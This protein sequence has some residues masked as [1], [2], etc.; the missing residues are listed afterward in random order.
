M[1]RPAVLV[2]NQDGWCLLDEI[3]GESLRHQTELEANL[4]R[5]VFDVLEY[6]ANS[7][8]DYKPNG[9]KEEDW[10]RLYDTCL[11]FLYRLLFILYAESRYL[12]P[13]RSH[14]VRSNRTYL[15]RFALATKLD[16]LRETEDYYT[17]DNLT[18]LY[19][20]LAKLF[21]LI[22]GNNPDIN[23][24]CGVTRYNG[25]LF[26]PALHPEIE[27]LRVPDKP[28]ADVLR[29]LMF[30]QPPSGRGAKQQAIS[31][32]D[33]IDYSS[34]HVRQL[35]DI[36]EG[37]LGAKFGMREG[38]LRLVN[39]DGKNHRDGVFYT[40]DWI[41]SYLLRETLQPLVDAVEASEDVTVATKAKSVEKQQTNAFALGVLEINLVDPAMGSG[42]FLVAATEWLADQVLYHPSTRTM[43]ESMVT[44]G[45]RDDIKKRGMV[46]VPP[47]VAQEDAEKAYWRRRIVESCV[48]GV[49]INPMAVELTKLSLWLTCI[50]VDEPLNFLDH[51]IRPG[52]A[53][54][55]APPESL[56]HAPLSAGSK[57]TV[58]TTLDNAVQ[59]AVR[60]CIAENTKIEETPSTEMQLVKRKED[61]WKKVRAKLAPV[62]SVA[63][64]WLAAL[65]GAL[66]NMEEDYRLIALNLLGLAGAEQKKAEKVAAGMAQTLAAKRADLQPFHW[67][68]EFPDIF[69]DDDGSLKSKDD[70]GFDAV[71]GNPPY[72]SVHTTMAAAYRTVLEK[73]CGY[74]E[75]LY[76]HFTDLGFNLLRAG[77]GFGFIVSDTFFTLDSKSKMRDW[78]QGHQLDVIGQCDP[79]DATVDAAIF[80]ARN[81][82]A[83]A[84]HRVLFVQARPRRDRVTGEMTRPEHDLHDLPQSD[85]I[86]SAHGEHKSLRFHRV[87]VTL[88]TDA[89]RRVFFEPTVGVL[90]LY[91]RFNDKVK[92]L[93][94]EWWDRVSTASNYSKNADAVRA[95]QDSL[96]PGDVTIVGLVADGAQGMRT[97]NNARYIGFLEGTPQ[98]STILQR[99]EEWTAA[100]LQDATVKPVFVRLLHE[101]GANVNRPTADG[102]AWE[103][104]VDAL[105]EQFDSDDLG[106]GKTALYRIIPKAL[107]ADESDFVFAWDTRRAE[108]LKKWQ[109]ERLFDDFWSGDLASGGDKW[110]K[111]KKAKTVSDAAFCELLAGVRAWV[112]SNEKSKRKARENALGLKSGEDY[113]TPDDCPRVAATYNGL[114]GRGRYVSFRKGDPE[115]SRWLDNA[116]LFIDWSA[117]SVEVL[118]T[119]AEA[120][121][122]GH[123]F[124]FTPGVTW[125][126][127]AN[128]VAMKS[129]FQAPCVFDADSMRLTPNNRLFDQMAFLALFN[130][131]VVSH[132]KMKFIKHTQKWEIGD[133]RQLPLVMPTKQQSRRLHDLAESAIEAKRLGYSN[134]SPS[135]TLAEF[136]REVADEMI[137]KAPAYLRPPAQMQLLS[138]PAHCLAVLELAVNWEAEKVYG[139]ESQGPFDEF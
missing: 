63:D 111:L 44:G 66:P 25:G 11:I 19:E 57:Q 127:V 112:A 76:L 138:T 64:L 128:H 119:A 33:A 12:L 110:A 99:R 20:D 31:T 129:R 106:F 15:T 75:D 117:K 53:L 6:L 71:L 79:F 38:S 39:A 84:K 107:V 49:D 45:S 52:N 98:A 29:Q 82:P 59:T 62:L 124:F 22:D 132:L 46:P 103:A 92:A 32:D 120:R 116:P 94:G 85:A 34:L 89:H 1:F 54:L 95:Y 50:A 80:V 60:N 104:A 47:G 136:C 10:P 58:M 125:T 90:K 70:A 135:H 16:R 56:N 17:S 130:S 42:H 21:H 122:Q 87:P 14:G 105:R 83:L 4:R 26:N 18:D 69:F 30:A 37:L 74:A 7:Y 97:G 67:H 40:P 88:F 134:Q 86:A 51:H 139:V 118:S 96:K 77:G 2:Q 91:D 78:L 81:S 100:W 126:A 137:E 24:E 36:Y 41:V 28:L 114:S 68:L 131:D 48:Y 35:G 23:A 115:G 9:L 133:L 65:D 8:N 113:L 123:R 121:W 108:L 109:G 27:K 3:R 72:V 43:T 101:H 13:V 55:Y 93:H 61:N 102:A 73:R 5:R